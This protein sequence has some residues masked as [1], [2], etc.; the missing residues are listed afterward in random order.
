MIEKNIEHALKTIHVLWK[1]GTIEKYAI[2]GAFATLFYME[3]IQ[4]Y[5]IDVFVFLKPTPAG[6][7]VLSPIYDRLV[8]DM[9]YTTHKEYILIEGI[10]VQFLPAHGEL[11]VEAIKKAVWKKLG[12]VRIRVF[13]PE[14]L[15]AIMLQTGRL[16]DRERLALFLE[17]AKF[18]KRLLNSILKSYDLRKK[19]Q[20]F[21]SGKS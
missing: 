8:K 1:E 10:P 5:D 7:F 16:K 4:T 19:W 3:P 18:D 12:R 6:L 17:E 11:I 14:Y 21:V 15:I 13:R 20:K 2:G 9:G